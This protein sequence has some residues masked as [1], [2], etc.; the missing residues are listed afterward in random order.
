M[1]GNI[2]RRMEP[3][4]LIVC[5]HVGCMGMSSLTAEIDAV[6]T[7]RA[8]KKNTVTGAGPFQAVNRWGRWNVCAPK[9]IPGCT[10]VPG[11]EISLTAT[12]VRK[13][14]RIPVYSGV[15]GEARLS[16]FANPRSIPL[17]RA[18]TWRLSTRCRFRRLQARY[19]MRV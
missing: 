5:Y 16:I 18:P 6:P 19:T 3:I 10:G 15:P 7:T 13:R 9:K 2:G 8:N 12:A 14:Q 17:E 1:G 4:N 11:S